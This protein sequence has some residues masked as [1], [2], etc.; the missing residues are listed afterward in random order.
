MFY[1]TYNCSVDDKGRVNVPVEFRESLHKAGDERIFITNCIANDVR[2]ID[3]YPVAAWQAFEA[4]LNAK[5][6]FD[7]VAR[8]LRKYYLSGVR[9][10][11]LDRQGRIL[12]PPPL[13]AYAGLKKDVCFVGVGETFEIWDREAW[14]PE[15]TSGEEFVNQNPERIKDLGV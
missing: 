12:L 13:R 11:P 2:W 15:Y 9:V 3:A 14:S 6:K 5:P 1:G 4:R 8:A 10:C 7:P